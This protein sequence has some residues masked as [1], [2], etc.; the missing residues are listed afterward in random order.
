VYDYNGTELRSD[1]LGPNT[2]Y[3]LWKQLSTADK[4]EVLTVF[5]FGPGWFQEQFGDNT[6]KMNDWRNIRRC[7]TPGAPVCGR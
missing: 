7:T 1:L 3:D 2:N 5:A 6:A 4:K